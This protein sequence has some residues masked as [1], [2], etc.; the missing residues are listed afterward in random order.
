MSKSHRERLGPLGRRGGP[1][2]LRA[3][4]LEQV[5][6]VVAVSDRPGERLLTAVLD[7]AGDDA[8]LKQALLRDPTVR[9]KP[10]IL[11]VQ[12]VVVIVRLGE[13]LSGGSPVT[14]HTVLTAHHTAEGRGA[15]SI[16]HSLATIWPL[17]RNP[18]SPPIAHALPGGMISAD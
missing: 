18:N 13:R 1:A 10:A 17:L 9:V 7:S 8:V 4:A 12:R 3:V 2:Q 11:A 5:I 15:R 16:C 6:Q 14:G